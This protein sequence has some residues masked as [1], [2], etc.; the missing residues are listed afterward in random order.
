ME[1][2]LPRKIEKPWGSELLFAYTPKYAGKIIFVKKEH[3]LSLQYHKQKDESM[4]IYEG[5][6]SME[7]KSSDGQLRFLILQQG[8]SIRIPPFTTH[9]VTAIE[10]AIILEVSTAELDDVKRI[11]DDYGRD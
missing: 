5:I 6:I 8:D 9:R 1:H 10:D 7:L 3:R 4:Y 2:K 11:K